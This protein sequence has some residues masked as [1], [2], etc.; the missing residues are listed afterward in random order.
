[1]TGSAIES[2]CSGVVRE[3]E[4]RL[5][6]LRMRDLLYSHVGLTDHSRTVVRI[7]TSHSDDSERIRQTFLHKAGIQPEVFGRQMEMEPARHGGFKAVA[8]K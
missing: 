7:V 1:M 6:F 5:D 3:P 4:P 2:H 8:A